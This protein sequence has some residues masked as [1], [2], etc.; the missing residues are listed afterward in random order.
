M[1]DMRMAKAA[2][3][4][5]VAVDGAQAVGMIPVDVREAGVDAYSASTHKWLQSPKGTPK[6]R[7]F[8]TGQRPPT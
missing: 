2:G 4:E 3:V 1:S 7:I 8:C 5:Y 6:Q